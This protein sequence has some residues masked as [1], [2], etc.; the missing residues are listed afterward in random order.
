MEVR[1]HINSVNQVNL[2]TVERT[3]FFKEVMLECLTA[4][5]NMST[6]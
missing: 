6:S 3:D 4:R 1:Q 2:V 5:K